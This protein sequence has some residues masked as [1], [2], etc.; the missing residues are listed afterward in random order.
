MLVNHFND[1]K[2][3]GRRGRYLQGAKLSRGHF[4]RG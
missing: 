2:P 4:T 3:K 1:S